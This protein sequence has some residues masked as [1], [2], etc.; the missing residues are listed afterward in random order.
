MSKQYGTD[1]DLDKLIDSDDYK[2]R[3][4]AAR[5]G[6]ALDRLLFD[7]N[8]ND[9]FEVAE[10][11]LNDHKYKT[12]FDW[13]K[14]NNVNI[15]INEWLTSDDWTKRREVAYYGY[16]L[17]ILAYDNDWG[18]RNAVYD[19]ILDHHYASVFAWAEDNNI[20][21]DIDE[22]LNSDNTYKKIAVVRAGYRLDILRNDKDETVR[23]Y[24][25]KYL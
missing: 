10:N 1:S 14:D 24:A 22:W 20:S 21:I 7:D 9:V 16:R 6:Y 15:D 23:N 4:K 3:I 2:D 12:I 8:N 11:Y 13:A 17:D 5:Q 25:C 18:V 19:Y